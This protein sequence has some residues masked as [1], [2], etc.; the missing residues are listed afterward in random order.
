MARIK[1]ILL[2]IIMGIIL[3]PWQMICLAHPFGHAH[4]H[5]HHEGPSPCEIRRIV[6]QQPGEHLLPPM[7]CE[8]ISDATD[9]YNQTQVERIVPTVQLIAVAAVVF[10]LVGF[11]ITEQPFLLPID[12]KCRS[13]TLLSDSPLRGPPLV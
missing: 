10:D 11:E 12:P 13:A 8:H 7:E 1:S 2:L 9:D 5:H 3:F 6:L 4:H